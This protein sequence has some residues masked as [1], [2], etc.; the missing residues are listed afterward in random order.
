M[1]L[2]LKTSNKIRL[3]ILSILAVGG[4]SLGIFTS[5]LQVHA[6]GTER[7]VATT[8]TDIGN[9]SVLANPCAT[10]QY[11][12]TNAV[13]GDIVNVAAGTY[14]ESI[15]VNKAL[16][17]KGA[18]ADV[19]ARTRGAVSET[20][21]E[22][23]DNGALNPF[24][25]RATSSDVTVNGFTITTESPTDASHGVEVSPG[26][27]AN[28]NVLN[29]IIKDHGWG[30]FAYAVTDINGLRVSKNL[31]TNNDRSDTSTD[32][33]LTGSVGTDIE[34]SDNVIK[35]SD[36]G[37]SAPKAAINLGA[38]TGQTLTNV[39]ILRNTVSNTGTF[40][41]LHSTDGATIQDN[42]ASSG[43]RTGLAL[44]L[45]LD[46][47]TIKNN[48]LTDFN[49]GME[50]AT[51]FPIGGAPATN[52]S[53]TDNTITNSQ[54]AG[55]VIRANAIASGIVFSNNT[56]TGNPV[57]I[58]NESSVAVAA[59]DNWWGCD[60]GPGQPGC[61]TFS[62]NVTVT[63]WLR[64]GVIPGVPNTST[65]LLSTPPLIASGVV[66]LLILAGGSYAVRKTR[67]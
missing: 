66:A 62:G 65:A 31:F 27:A 6:L 20:I 8:G 1:R 2:Q 28:L 3:S 34:I 18:Q 4:A 14:T 50:F 22:V 56:F 11:A 57:G 35:D 44:N 45:K 52:V 54:Q 26:G 5:T 25:I 17:L 15:I 60:A 63:S 37:V 16:T 39:R 55:V 42:V 21:I 9:C 47:I 40:L 67:S 30:L 49:Y 53:V 32:M 10:V 38:D 43:S 12:V 19:D 13:A 29:N 64:Q 61:D 46:N 48:K 41:V 7:Y 59:N 23:P 51:N 58:Q 33:Y 36:N 24:A